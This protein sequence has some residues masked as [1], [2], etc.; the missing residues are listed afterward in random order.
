MAAAEATKKAIDGLPG[1]AAFKN[2][3]LASPLPGRKLRPAQ[4][5]P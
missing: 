4:P 3:P 2:A 1:G 5:L